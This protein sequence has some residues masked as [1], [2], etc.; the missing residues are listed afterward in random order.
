MEP[1]IVEIVSFIL[2]E[3]FRMN[4]EGLIYLEI[5]IQ[6]ARHSLNSVISG[7]SLHNLKNLEFRNSV[8]IFDLGVECSAHHFTAFIPLVAIRYNLKR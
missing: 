6:V 8:S 3:G 2:R 1:E 5:Q 4:H 7:L